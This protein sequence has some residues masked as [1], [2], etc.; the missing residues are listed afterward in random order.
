MTNGNLG[1]E[2]TFRQVDKLGECPHCKGKGKLTFYILDPKC[3]VCGGTGQLE[4]CKID[5]ALS[6]PQSFDRY[7]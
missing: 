2:S 6:S 1:L 4:K 5:Q 7:K 3:S